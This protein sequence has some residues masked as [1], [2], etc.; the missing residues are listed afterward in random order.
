MRAVGTRLDGDTE[1]TDFAWSS[2]GTGTMT[3]RRDEDGLITLLAVA[4]DRARSRRNAHARLTGGTST[5]PGED[6]AP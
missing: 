3:I 1:V 6:S 2:G 5:R 4:F